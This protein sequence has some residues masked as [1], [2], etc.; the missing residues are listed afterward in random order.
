MHSI[1]IVEDDMNI[2]GLLKEAL[3][4]ADYLCTCARQKD[5]KGRRLYDISSEISRTVYFCQ[6]QWNKRRCGCCDT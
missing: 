5:K 1:L 4:K 3:E 6:F 2:N